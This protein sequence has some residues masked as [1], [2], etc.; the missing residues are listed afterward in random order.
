MFRI[1]WPA[2]SYKTSTLRLL[3]PAT[4]GERR[5]FT[6]A[7]EALADVLEANPGIRDS[8]GVTESIAELRS[9]DLRAPDGFTWHHHQDFWRIELVPAPVHEPV[10]HTG[11]IALWPRLADYLGLS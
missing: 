8:L 1:L 5:H 2:L 4:G 3:L 7:N 10:N 9:G 6:E 11:R